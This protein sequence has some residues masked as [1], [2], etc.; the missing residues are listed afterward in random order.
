MSTNFNE[1]M[2]VKTKT[3]FAGTV[4]YEN[5]IIDIPGGGS[6]GLG[7][8]IITTAGSSGGGGG[9]AGSGV[10]GLGSGIG[11]MCIVTVQ[12]GSTTVS[13]ICGRIISPFGPIKS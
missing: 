13:Q 1:D 6:G 9:G 4:V 2:L 5:E 11:H 3:L 10:L 12:S 8:S 7:S